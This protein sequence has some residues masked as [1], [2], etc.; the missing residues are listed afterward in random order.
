MEDVIFILL[1]EDETTIEHYM[2]TLKQ[3]RRA[4]V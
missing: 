3:Y 1:G 2:E 4:F